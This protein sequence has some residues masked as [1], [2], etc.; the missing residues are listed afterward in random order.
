MIP[1]GAFPPAAAPGVGGA[2]AAAA[3]GAAAPAQAATACICVVNMFTEA[4][5]TN[6]EEYVDVMQDLQEECGKLGNVVDLKVPRPS[7]PGMVGQGHYGNAFVLFS[8]AQEA[9]AAKDALH[10]RSFDGLVLD[11]TFVPGIPTE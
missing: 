11:V 7:G 10:G 1:P 8:S 9:Q 3:A 6:D 4:V 5:L 2:V